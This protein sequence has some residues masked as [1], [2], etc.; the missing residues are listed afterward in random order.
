MRLSALVGPLVLLAARAAL[1]VI[2]TG[3]VGFQ[4]PLARPQFAELLCAPSREAGWGVP[5][6]ESHNSRWK[7]LRL[8]GSDGCAAFTLPP[9]APT[10]EP[11]RA[12]PPATLVVADR[13]GCAFVEKARNAQL[14]GAKGLV[15]RGTRRAAF[16]AI[17]AARNG[18]GGR[19]D[20]AEAPV[21]PPFDYDCSRGESFV[22]AVADPAWAT[23]DAAC[24]S[25]ARCA[26]R[27]CMLTG[28]V[29]A[30]KGG[31]QLCCLWDTYVLMGANRSDAANLSI[32][33]VYV[34]IADGQ[35][36]ERSLHSYPAL[37]IRTYQREVPLLDVSSV[38]LWALGV[39]TAVGGAYYSAAADRRSW[40]I[41]TDPNASERKRLEHEQQQQQQRGRR[42]DD[43][44]D[45]WEIDAKHAVGFIVSAGV[46]LTVF[47]YVKLGGVLPI[48]F[49][50]AAAGTMTQLVMAPLLD[51]ACPAVASRQLSLS[52]GGDSVP[53]ADVLGLMLS[54]GLALVWYLNR[55]TC[56]YLQDVFG[57]SLCVVFLR[58][59]QL[60]SLK[61]ATILLAL[62]FVYD[63]FFVFVSP[64]IFGSSVMEDVA[65]GG[66][67][68]YTRSDYPGVDFCERY[69]AYPACV[70]PEPMPMLLV[71][72]RIM[73]WV[74]GVSMLGLGDIIIPGLL[75]SFALRFDYSP[76]SLGEGYYRSVCIGY[77][78]GLGLANIAVSVMQMG[79]PALMYLVPT[80]LGTVVALAWK[81]G[82]LKAMWTGVGLAGDSRESDDELEV[83][84]AGYNVV[85]RV[86]P[87]SSGGASSNSS[88]VVNDGAG[89]HD[90]VPLLGQSP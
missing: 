71:L 32:P 22:A 43:S 83:G 17:A 39:A 59:V 44:D 5:L 13:G 9:P 3:R 24:R 82:D 6:P 20:T 52:A 8:L 48:L 15:V 79:Q 11:R 56:W 74:G 26:S 49:C 68:A 29:D 65:T 34:T 88:Q 30:Q 35:Q 14:A 81:N 58:T 2:P 23:D 85:P 40:R 37:Q 41:R 1:A 89:S 86:A 27:M 75:L 57:I 19:N 31:H 80:T 51:A 77:A 63:V 62:A 18:S 69:P 60:P 76:R 55:R 36:I 47:Y 42:H 4:L 87:G 72:P 70:D 54:A 53:L 38:L 46:F 33:V 16:E 28:E 7:T 84:D 12:P 90:S 45:I 64:A 66:P 73:D 78:V 21:K 25:H 10:L 67:A 50:L 61:V